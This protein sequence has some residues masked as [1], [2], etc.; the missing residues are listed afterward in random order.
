LFSFFLVQATPGSIRPGSGFQILTLTQSGGDGAD[1][2]ASRRFVGL[3]PRGRGGVV[4]RPQSA[5]DCV[6]LTPRGDMS[7]PQS[8]RG[9]VASNG[10]RLHSPRSPKV[11]RRDLC[12]CHFA[13]TC[14]TS[15]IHL[16][17]TTWRVWSSPCNEVCECNEVGKCLEC[18]EV[19]KCLLCIFEG[20]RMLVHL[21]PCAFTPRMYTRMH[22]GVV[23]GCIFTFADFML[24]AT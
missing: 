14:V 8:A 3:T 16:L 18:N 2:I 1:V 21:C 7:R 17:V 24:I 9:S 20:V 22:T 15:L 13:F 19:G 5:R 10:S 11:S 4:S 6:G 12:V 23:S